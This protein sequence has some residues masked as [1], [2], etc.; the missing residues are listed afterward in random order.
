L[1]HKYF[2]IKIRISSKKQA[3]IAKQNPGEQITPEL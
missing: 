1:Q 2:N 3:E